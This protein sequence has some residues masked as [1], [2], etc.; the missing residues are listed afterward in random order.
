MFIESVR[1]RATCNAI[2]SSH[3]V[4]SHR[5][6]TT[7]STLSSVLPR[8]SRSFSRWFLSPRLRLFLLLLTYSFSTPFRLVR[9]FVSLLTPGRSVRFFIQNPVSSF[10]L[11]ISF[12]PS[13]FSRIPPIFP[14]YS[15]STFPSSI[16]CVRFLAGTPRL[17]PPHFIHRLHDVHSILS[18]L[19]EDSRD[20]TP[21]SHFLLRP[22]SQPRSFLAARKG[23]GIETVAESITSAI[24]TSHP[25][26]VNRPSRVSILWEPVCHL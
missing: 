22:A 24:S 12:S 13:R 19:L 3:L 21:S 8:V 15:F 11:W 9:P 7:G 6:C 20:L 16:S 10:T 14:S 17:V 23:E 18:H 26:L 5:P 4:S 1:A 2:I 25:S